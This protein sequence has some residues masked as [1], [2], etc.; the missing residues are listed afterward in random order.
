MAPLY[1]NIILPLIQSNKKEINSFERCVYKSMEIKK[2]K[3]I[4][5]VKIY[6]ID[7]VCLTELIDAYHT[8]NKT[9]YYKPNCICVLNLANAEKAGGGVLNGAFAQEEE[10]FR[11]TNLNLS[12]GIGEYKPP[13]KFSE[14]EVFYSNNITVITTQLYDTYESDIRFGVISAAALSYDGTLSE[15]WDKRMKMAKKVELVEEKGEM[16]M[17]RKT[18]ENIFIT[19]HK[20]EHKI[21]VLGSIGCG[22]FNNDAMVVARMFKDAIDKYGHWFNEIYFSIMKFNNVIPSGS[23]INEKIN[24]NGFNE[25]IDTYNYNSFKR[26]LFESPASSQ[27]NEEKKDDANIPLIDVNANKQSN[28]TNGYT[29]INSQIEPSYINKWIV[30][31]T[32]IGLC[33]IGLS[34]YGVNRKK[35]HKRDN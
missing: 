27:L 23:W 7:V 8:K 26:V 20:K 3:K 14:G 17:L 9:E 34:I 5:I 33:I 29:D 10:L 16:Y 18:I 24:P 22:A 35:K 11:R 6:N 31:G 21:L 1:K 30:G 13:M 19:A 4:P 28:N 32:I 2:N 15:K 25:G 12:L